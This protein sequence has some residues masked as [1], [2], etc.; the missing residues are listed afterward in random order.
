MPTTAGVRSTLVAATQLAATTGCA[1]EVET[2]NATPILDVVA[3]A[4]S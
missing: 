4:G 1:G 3:S 2:P